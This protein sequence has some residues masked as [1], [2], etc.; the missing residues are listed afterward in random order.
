MRRVYIEHTDQW[1]VES[2]GNGWGY[3]FTHKPTG[4]TAWLQDD[5][6]LE[7]REDYEA[8]EKAY[9]T[10]GTAWH[11]ATWNECLAELIEPYIMEAT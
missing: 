1:I 4:S 8:M 6:A 10:P 7:W 11:T 2:V 9:S 5:D 3:S